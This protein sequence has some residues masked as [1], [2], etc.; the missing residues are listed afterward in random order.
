MEQERSITT[1]MVKG[2]TAMA[3][4]A[5]MW[6]GAG[7]PA[8][9][10]A[11]AEGSG[12]FD[13]V[14]VG[15]FSLGGRAAYYDPKEGDARWFGGAQARLH[16]G[17]YFAVEGSVDYRHYDVGA[18]RV[19]MFPVQ[20]SA[21]IYPFGLRRI[22]PFILGG[23]GWYYTRVEQGGQHDTQNRFGAHVGGGLQFFMNEHWSMDTSYR[24]LW[25]ESLESKSASL[26]NKKFNDN[27]HMFTVGLNYHF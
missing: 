6:M 11:M 23:G 27:G 10:S 2:I 24:Y 25:L 20:V 4:A 12:P 1:T 16:L 14:K 17:S 9:D 13:E 7:L 18:N 3:M 19:R 22:S 5:T 8:V 21:M 26:G 15:G